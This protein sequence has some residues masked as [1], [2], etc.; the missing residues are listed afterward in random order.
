MVRTVFLASLVVFSAGCSQDSGLSSIEEQYVTPVIHVAGPQAADWL[1]A[2]SVVVNGTAVGLTD[3]LVNDVPTLLDG[4]EFQSTIG[5]ERGINRVEVKGTDGRGDTKYIRH[6]VIAGDFADT[7]K[8]MKDALHLRLNQGGLDAV[9]E[10]V[11]DAIDPE[12]IA[13]S[14]AGT[15]VYEAQYGLFSWEAIDMTA[16]LM[17]LSFD[18]L[19][20]ELKP[21]SNRLYLTVEIPDL[22]TELWTFGAVFGI[23]F[24]VDAF[25]WADSVIIEG[26]V[27]IDAD[28]GELEVAFENPEVALYGFGYDTSLIPYGIETLVFVDE[29]RGYLED[30]LVD[31]ISEK[32]PE[33][34]DEQLAGLDLSF[35][36]EMFGQDMK[37]EA[38]FA[39]ADIDH[40]GVAL[41][42]DIDVDMGSEDLHEAPGYL[43]APEATMELSTKSDVAFGLTDNVFNRVL[44]GVWQSGM[45]D[46]TMSTE[47]ESL[48][49]AIALMLKAD[50]AAIKIDAP[51]PPVMVQRD[52]ELVIEVGEL[53]VTIDTPNGEFGDHLEAAISG[54]IPVNLVGQ[55]GELLIELGDADLMFMV[56]DSDWGAASNEAVTNLLSQML[57]PRLLLMGVGELAFPL[58]ALTDNIGIKSVKVNTEDN[59]YST[60]LRINLEK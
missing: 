23:D 45:L 19:N 42:V 12:E 27:T 9:C 34:L 49:A 6:S 38:E 46:M 31:T 55:D 44:H 51:L 28:D 36:T 7:N 29:V 33:I 15:P 20:A 53:M 11:N 22:D 16:L 40:D 21:G 2:T 3:L 60:A 24:D 56:R 41:V 14:V 43:S 35:E 48:D 59:E 5:L 47:D 4:D 10:I 8:T 50:S 18:K 25:V 57:D 17:D 58:P 52:G 13:D 30:M 37:L 32:V 39:E 1:P 26:E 54:A